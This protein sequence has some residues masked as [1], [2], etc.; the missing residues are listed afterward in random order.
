MFT[1]YHVYTVTSTSML[2]YLDVTTDNSNVLLT[3]RN[4]DTYID[5]SEETLET[6][7]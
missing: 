7:F 4:F 6:E 2:I 5:V 3:K 1:S